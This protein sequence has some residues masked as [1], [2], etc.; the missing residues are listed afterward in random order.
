MRRTLN[1]NTCR[2]SI[3]RSR[4]NGGRSIAWRGHLKMMAAAQPSLSGAIRKTIN[5]PEESTV[6]D[7]MEAYIESWK[8]GIKAVAIYRDNSKRC[9]TA[10]RGGRD[11]K[12]GTGGAARTIGSG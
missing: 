10:L 5:M 7:M 4:L 1:R 11:K 3:A 6:E 12:T 9:A 8:L 2:C